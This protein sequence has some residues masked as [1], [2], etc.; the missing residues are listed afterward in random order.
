MENNKHNQLMWAVRA[1][2][3][4]AAHAILVKQNLIV[5]SKQGV[6]DLSSLPADRNAFY[7]ATAAGGEKVNPTAIRGVGG[8]FFRFVHEMQVGDTIL[9]P[10][11]F[12]KKIHFGI[13]RGSYRYDPVISAQF[14]HTRPVSW[15][16]AFPKAVLSTY[17]KRELGAARTLFRIKTHVEEILQVFAK[18]I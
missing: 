18:V 17:A 5:L 10:C 1:G 15:E 16:G 9:Y 14:P 4:G 2:E 13:I 12:D 7:R 8:K 11:L 3:K 6:G